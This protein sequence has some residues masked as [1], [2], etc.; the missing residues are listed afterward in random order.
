[1][2][3]PLVAC[4]VTSSTPPD[5]SIF[6]PL[7]LR[8]A[9]RV[10]G[11][12][13]RSKNTWCSDQSIRAS[14]TTFSVTSPLWSA[15]CLATKYAE[16]KSSVS[17]PGSFPAPKVSIGGFSKSVTSC[18]KYSIICSVVL[19]SVAAPIASPAPAP[20]NPPNILSYILTPP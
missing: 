6:S 14:C 10:V 18:P 9:R 17:C 7:Y 19:A 16:L 8:I 5:F 2:A 1:M 4:R 11:P 15:I 13:N 3:A 12:A 20:I